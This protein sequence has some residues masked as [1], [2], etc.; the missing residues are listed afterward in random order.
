VEARPIN[1]RP[2]EGITINF[3]TSFAF[4]QFTYT[5]FQFIPVLF[6]H[7]MTARKGFPT[8]EESYISWLLWIVVCIVALGFPNKYFERLAYFEDLVP[9]SDDPTAPV[10]PWSHP[11]TF[12]DRGDPKGVA[13]KTM[14]QKQQEEWDRLNIAVGFS[15][16]RSISRNVLTTC[17]VDVCNYSH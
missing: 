16:T 1:P 11:K 3:A 10:R 5:A 17:Y 15:G 13:Q 8:V 9:G 12:S 6:L 4:S 7:R 2:S 14:R